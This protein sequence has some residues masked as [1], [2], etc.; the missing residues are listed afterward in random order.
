MPGISNLAI[1]IKMQSMK[2]LVVLVLLITNSL[3]IQAQEAEMLNLN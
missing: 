1:E 3:A 2:K